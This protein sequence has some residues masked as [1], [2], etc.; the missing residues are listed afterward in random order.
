MLQTWL[1]FVLFKVLCLHFHKNQLHFGL[2]YF[3]DITSFS[4]IILLFSAY[5]KL[6]LRMIPVILSNTFLESSFQLIVNLK[7]VQIFSMK[8]FRLLS[9]CVKLSNP[10]SVSSQRVI[11]KS[12]FLRSKKPPSANHSKHLLM[13]VLSKDTVKARIHFT[14]EMNN[15]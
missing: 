12:L 13:R 6:N 11:L 4:K 9:L 2:F 1:I 5:N 7:S 8:S 3:V 14:Q 10:K 15:I